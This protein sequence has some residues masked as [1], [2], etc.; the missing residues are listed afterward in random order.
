MTDTNVKTYTR[1]SDA[2]RGAKRAHGDNW[3]E[4]YQVVAVEG[5]F[6]IEAKKAEPVKETKPAK[7]EAKPAAAKPA[8]KP[9]TKK[10]PAKVKA[11]PVKETVAAITETVIATELAEADKPTVAPV[12]VAPVAEQ[13]APVVGDLVAE[14][15]ASTQ[16]LQSGLKAPAKALMSVASKPAAQTPAKAATPVE[17]A[18]G[19][20][21]ISDEQV[22]ARRRLTD[23]IAKQTGIFTVKGAVKA[24]KLKKMHISNGFRWAEQTGL[25]ERV[26]YKIEK[27]PGRREVN[28]KQKG[29]VIAKAA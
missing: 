14:L 4:L 21:P 17:K 25:I 6:A 16:A 3:A 22:K 29:A 28:Y 2:N 10:A 11:E 15:K 5:G 13:K 23:W 7:A 20:R 26:D 27:R 1:K 12:E 19:G 8:S 18:K 24:L 9:A